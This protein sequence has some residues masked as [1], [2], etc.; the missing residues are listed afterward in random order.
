MN[1]KLIKAKML[2]FWLNIDDFLKF[3]R[4]FSSIK[5]SGFFTLELFKPTRVEFSFGISNQNVL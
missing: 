2:K 4:Q 3:L 1:K 5:V